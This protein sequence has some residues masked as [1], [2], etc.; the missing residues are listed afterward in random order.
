MGTPN[1][2]TA[3]REELTASEQ[4]NRG[5]KLAGSPLPALRGG[6]G[7]CLLQAS[8]TSVLYGGG[9]K[10]GRESAFHPIL[11]CSLS[12]IEP[13]SSDSAPPPQMPV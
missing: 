1:E 2:R 10:W 3:A 7:R 13:D 4:G 12:S 8:Q 9:V 11:L 5:V 6:G